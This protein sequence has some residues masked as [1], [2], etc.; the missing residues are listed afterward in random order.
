MVTLG[1]RWLSSQI[2]GLD[3]LHTLPGY[4]SS[5]ADQL[6]REIPKLI[7]PCFRES[8]TLLRNLGQRC[9]NVVALPRQLRIKLHL[10][11]FV[12]VGIP[13][14][15][16]LIIR[17]SELYITKF[18]FKTEPWLLKSNTLINLHVFYPSAF[19]ITADTFL[20]GFFK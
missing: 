6:W 14:F 1:E 11:R 3:C 8:L 17:K 19:L 9:D 4:S 2:D 18:L 16:S 10:L 20:N 7:E 15:W 13:K 5:S 12:N